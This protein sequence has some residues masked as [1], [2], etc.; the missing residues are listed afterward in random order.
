MR[1][2]PGARWV[3]DRLW[4]RVCGQLALVGAGLV[5]AFVVLGHQAQVTFLNS[6]T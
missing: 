5:L 3:L 2:T 4:S 1:E 6:F